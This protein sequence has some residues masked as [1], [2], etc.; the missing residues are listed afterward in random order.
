MKKYQYF[1]IIY[2]DWRSKI[3]KNYLI[4]RLIMNLWIFWGGKIP[5]FFYYAYGYWLKVGRKHLISE[6]ITNSWIFWD[7]KIFFHYIY[8]WKIENRKKLFDSRVNH[9]SRGFFGMKRYRYF[10][11]ICTDCYWSKIE[12]RKKLYDSRINQEFVNFLGWKNIDIFL[13]YVFLLLLMKNRKLEKKS[14]RWFRWIITVIW[15]RSRIF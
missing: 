5:I 2:T 4:L 11:I 7:E 8:G 1:F 13:L 3:G 10:S 12:S 15:T 14:G 9:E 6:L